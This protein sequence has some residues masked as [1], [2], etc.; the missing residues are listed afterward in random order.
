MPKRFDTPGGGPSQRQL[1]VAETI[2]RTLS[3]VLARGDTH[4]PE[5]SRMS[6]TVS[7]VRC[8]PDLRHATAF[9]LPLGGRDVAAALEALARNAPELRRAVVKNL[10]LK[11]APDLKFVADESFDN[12]DATR[13]LLEDDVVRR[14]LDRSDDGAE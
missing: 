3:E 1:R 11:Y 14:D 2:R 5:L 9:V 6:I 7:E 10:H 12:A 13:R 4:D 8:S